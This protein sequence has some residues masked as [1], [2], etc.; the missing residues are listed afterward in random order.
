MGCD[1]LIILVQLTGCGFNP[2]T[3]VG[4]DLIFVVLMQITLVFQSTH[5]RG[6]RQKRLSGLYARP[7]V[8]IHAPTWGATEHRLLP[9]ALDAVSI[10][11]P[12][13]GATRMLSLRPAR[14][15]RFQSTHPRGVRLNYLLILLVHISFNPR[16]HVGCDTGE[17]IGNTQLPIV[18]IHAPTWGATHTYSANI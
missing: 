3:H 10:H 18:S 17:I 14:Q 2:R 15:K 11:A 7:G 5:P 4:C 13:W 6:V 16:T 1:Y 9:V 12:T 8:S